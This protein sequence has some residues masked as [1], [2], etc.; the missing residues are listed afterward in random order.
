MMNMSVL[1]KSWMVWGILLVRARARS[2]CDAT[3]VMSVYL[4]WNKWGECDTNK[5]CA[6][7]EPE[8]EKYNANGESGD[9]N[10]DTSGERVMYDATN[11]KGAIY[12][13]SH[14]WDATKDDTN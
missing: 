13:N 6:I 9:I 14:K 1:M 3:K 10:D 8:N 5:V 7:D 4:R 12:E 2:R 11:A